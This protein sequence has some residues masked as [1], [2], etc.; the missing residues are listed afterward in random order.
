MLRFANFKSMIKYC[1]FNSE[2]LIRRFSSIL[3]VLQ[4][5][6]NCV[7]ISLFC[8]DFRNRLFLSC[9]IK[10]SFLTFRFFVFFSFL[11]DELNIID[12]IIWRRRDVFVVVSKNI[13]SIFEFFCVL[14]ALRRRLF[15]V[16][17]FSYSDTRRHIER[18][19]L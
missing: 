16:Y 6:V 17:I 11:R 18:L 4:R 13:L 8:K 1:R 19:F 9:K 10:Y 15:F 3:I 14:F 7:F 5:R 12:I 2:I